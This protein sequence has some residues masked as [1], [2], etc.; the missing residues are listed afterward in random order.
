ML[1]TAKRATE[2]RR[3]RSSCVSYRISKEDGESEGRS[4][5]LVGRALPGWKAGDARRNNQAGILDMRLDWARVALR[6]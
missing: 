5:G 6:V 3:R 1:R 4:P 2:R